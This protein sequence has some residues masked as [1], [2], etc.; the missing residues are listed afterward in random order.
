MRQRAGGIWTLRSR[1]TLLATA[2]V[3]AVLV[4][5]GFGLVQ[6]QQRV[7]LQGVD[8]ALAQRADNLR[9]ALAHDRG[10]RVLPAEGDR[11]DSFLQLIDASGAVTTSSANARAVPAVSPPLRSGARPVHRIVSVPQLSTH[12]YRVLVRLTPTPGGPQTLV[13]AKNVDDV[14]DS[15]RLLEQSLAVAVPAV[16]ALLAALVWWLTGRVLRPV[17]QAGER[18]RQFV[19]DAAHELRGPL[20]RIRSAVEVAIEHPASAPPH[21]IYAEVLADSSE[22]QRLLDDLL[23]LARHD[24]VRTSAAVTEPVDLDDVVL[25]EVSRVRARNRIGVDISKV[26]P[27]RVSGE[28]PQL[29]RLVRNLL[30]NAERHAVR[31]VH[32]EL[33]ERGPYS[34]LVVDDD[35]PGIAAE[36]REAVFGRFVRLD[37]ARSPESGGAGLG[38]AIVAGIV[39]RH[40]GTVTIGASARGGARVTV[41]L[42]APR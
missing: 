5:S 32:V 42:P 16:V 38:L 30:D 7:L 41:R 37:P 28:A 6:V 27:A 29:A 14:A 9:T 25:E 22:L 11:E 21:E 8:E 2:V 36:H 3:L 4:L 15:V 12:D 1:L 26:G 24:E 39:R 10:D 20:T 23:F 13:V 19:A 35:G 17:S 33:G 40:G 31:E 18:Q 34:E